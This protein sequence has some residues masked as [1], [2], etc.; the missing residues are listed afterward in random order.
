MIEA[1]GGALGVAAS[2]G[3]EALF[4]GVDLLRFT[5]VPGL[6]LAGSIL[7]KIWDAVNKVEVSLMGTTF[8]APLLLLTVYLSRRIVSCLY[9]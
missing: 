3:H 7:L 9:A 6:E 1:I 8:V 4:S 2:F 5:P